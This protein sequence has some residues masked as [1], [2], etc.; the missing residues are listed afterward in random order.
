MNH[1]TPSNTHHTFP[2]T[3]GQ[4]LGEPTYYPCHPL[5]SIEKLKIRPLT[6][7]RYKFAR[8]TATELH[9]E[10]RQA[11]R[12]S[13]E[14]PVE[15][16][17]PTRGHWIRFRR[18][19]SPTHDPARKD[20]ASL[21]A[22]LRLLGRFSMWLARLDEAVAPSGPGQTRCLFSTSGEFRHKALS[23]FATYPR[24]LRVGKVIN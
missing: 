7:T 9:R 15:E 4:Q 19:Q 14:C 8:P 5:C 10:A 1:T 12:A 16:G 22:Y 11:P 17:A 18:G 20:S 23:D 2:H 24:L 21:S 3:S 6:R 13:S